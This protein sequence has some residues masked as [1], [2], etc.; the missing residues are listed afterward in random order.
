MKGLFCCFPSEYLYNFS[1]FGIKHQ[2]FP[3]HMGSSRPPKS[4][5]AQYIDPEQLFPMTPQEIF[6]PFWLFAN[7]PEPLFPLSPEYVDLYQRSNHFAEKL[8]SPSTS[9]PRLKLR[10]SKYSMISSINDYSS[11]QLE[12]G[13]FLALCRVLI[14]KQKTITNAITDA[15]V[16]EAMLQGYDALFS[17]KT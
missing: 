13:I 17:S 4:P 1:V 2:H 6:R 3:E 12:N 5:L 11:S 14:I 15:E 7:Q 9:L 16:T 10:F 8:A